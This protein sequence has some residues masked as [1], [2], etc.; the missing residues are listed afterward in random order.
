MGKTGRGKWGHHKLHRVHAEGLAEEMCI[1]DKTRK[2]RHGIPTKHTAPRS[3]L[4]LPLEQSWRSCVEGDITVTQQSPQAPQTMASNPVVGRQDGP[5]PSGR[6]WQPSEGV[7]PFCISCGLALM[8][9]QVATTP[10]ASAC[11]PY[12]LLLSVCIAYPA[13]PWS[14][15]S[16]HGRWPGGTRSSP[17]SFVTS[18]LIASRAGIHSYWRGRSSMV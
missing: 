17:W 9:Q 11:F 5:I 3:I 8:E 15:G 13:S 1:V 14:G 10:L 18:G 16:A 12:L 6:N 4:A 7:G 2:R